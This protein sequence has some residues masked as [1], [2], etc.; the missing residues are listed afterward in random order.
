MHPT[1]VAREVVMEWMVERGVLEQRRR[2]V[3][4]GKGGGLVVYLAGRIVL[5]RVG[6]ATRGGCALGGWTAVVA[7]SRAGYG[8][9]Y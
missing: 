9:V 6:K 2:V 5:L 1:A 4:Q 8:L 7:S 3:S